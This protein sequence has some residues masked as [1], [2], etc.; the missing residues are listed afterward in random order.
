MKSRLMYYALAVFACIAIM[1][2]SALLM[3]ILHLQGFM[4][5]IAL[6]VMFTLMTFAW[7]AIVK[8]APKTNDNDANDRVT[9]K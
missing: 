8:L 2:A 4:N 5:I 9:D 1:V 6:A 7:K 3:A